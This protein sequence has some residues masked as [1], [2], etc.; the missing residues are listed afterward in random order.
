MLE[1]LCD[2]LLEK[3]GL[4]LDEMAIFLWDDFRMLV[5]TS[6]IRRALAF[7]G[8]SKKNYPAEGQ[9]TEHRV[10][11]ILSSQYLGIRIV[12]PGLRR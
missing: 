4:Y 6:C 5:T 9:G 2:R 12:P 3:P 11:R 8:W 7:K 10:M 1:A